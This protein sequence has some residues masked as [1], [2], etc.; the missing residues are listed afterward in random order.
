LHGPSAW[1]VSGDGCHHLGPLLRGY[2]ASDEHL[3]ALPTL[4][5]FED[6]AFTLLPIRTH[7]PRL[8]TSGVGNI[9]LD[10]GLLGGGKPR[11]VGMPE[12]GD[13]LILDNQLV[14]RRHELN[15]PLQI[16]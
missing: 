10:E 16:S 15:P 9:A 7:L 12:C 4:D 5:F 11:A 3:L 13:F 14:Q 2:E 6:D 8:K 1:L